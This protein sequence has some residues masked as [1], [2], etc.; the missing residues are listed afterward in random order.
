MVHAHH[1]HVTRDIKPEG[2]CPACDAYHA[3]QRMREEGTTFSPDLA[4]LKYNLKAYPKAER[5]GI[6][7]ESIRHII[8]RL[9]SAEGSLDLIGY[10]L[11]GNGEESRKLLMIAN[12]LRGVSNGTEGQ[13][14]NGS[15]A[16]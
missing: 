3:T 6:T 4:T 16:E 7:A 8:N 15:G 10:I 12:V 11:K 2:E 9:E 1:N 13:E 14:S 5:F